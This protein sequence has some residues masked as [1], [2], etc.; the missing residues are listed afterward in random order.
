LG[1][2][3]WVYVTGTATVTVNF[4]NNNTIIS[5]DVFVVT[6]PHPG[7]NVQIIPCGWQNAPSGTNNISVHF[8]KYVSLANPTGIAFR[9]F[10]RVC[11]CD[12]GEIRAL[13]FQ[14]HLGG[15]DPMTFE[16]VDSKEMQVAKEYI[17]SKYDKNITEVQSRI[18]GQITT[19]RNNSAP[20]IT[21]KRQFDYLEY[22]DSRW[23]DDCV[24]SGNV[25]L[26]DM[27]SDHIDRFVRMNIVDGNVPTYGQ[28]I[29]LV[30]S[31]T[32]SEEFLL[33]Y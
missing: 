17:T 16:C 3:D 11:A 25:W 6:Q 8:N 9:M 31:V 30:V 23:L 24:S 28:E 10:G 22:E 27:F 7:G 26:L 5:T 21:M 29:E 13:Y 12:N 18:N 20:V 1:T 33:P 15:L 4:W 14:N 19:A 32:Y 2:Y